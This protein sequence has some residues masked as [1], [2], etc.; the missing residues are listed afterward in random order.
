M[1]FSLKAPLKGAFANKYFCLFSTSRFV[2]LKG[3][4]L[5]SKRQFVAE[6]LVSHLQ[7]CPLRHSKPEEKDFF[8]N[9]E[10]IYVDSRQSVIGNN[11]KKELPVRGAVILAEKYEYLNTIYAYL[12]EKD[13]SNSLSI[14][15]LGNSI[16]NICPVIEYQ[17][18]R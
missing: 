6:Y 3:N 5:S 1:K 14:V 2:T 12:R 4:S 10:T 8:R 18:A 7:S 16:A 11:K 15:R 9:T 13:T 17:V